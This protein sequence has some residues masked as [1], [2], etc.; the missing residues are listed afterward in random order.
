ML[1]EYSPAALGQQ[2]GRISSVPQRCIQV[3]AVDLVN[4][5]NAFRYA[6]MI[7][8]RSSGR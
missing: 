1:H 8:L 3:A 5:N 2:E 6:A 7:H 4:I